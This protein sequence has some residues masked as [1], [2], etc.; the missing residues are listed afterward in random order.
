MALLLNGHPNSYSSA[1]MHPCCDFSHLIDAF[2]KEPR[3][4]TQLLW[5]AVGLLSSLFVIQLLTGLLSHSLSLL[6]DAGH[7][8]SDVIALG[9]SLAATRL[10]QQPAAGQA[11]FGHRRVEVLA[12]LV[13]G[14]ALLAIATIVAKEA[15]ER[16]QSSEP[17]LG[18]PMLIVAG[19]G[20]AVNSINI[21]LLYKASRNDLNIRG[22]FLHVVAD[23]ASSLGILFAALLIYL[24]NWTWIDAGVSLLIAISISLS[25]IPLV[26]D[27]LEVL[28][29]YAPRSVDPAKVEAALKSF[30]A[31]CE[32]E[33]LRI[34]TIGSGQ[35]AL[36]AHLIVDVT[37]GGERD[38]LIKQL[39]N[40][41]EREFDIGESTLQLTHHHSTELIELHPLLR[42]SLSAKLN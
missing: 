5:A 18:L 21:T 39:Q 40:H 42:S 25:S 4:K 12:A 14:L 35:V 23:T 2:S 36:C 11:T 31:V 9:I 30:V 16:F 6:A 3:Q 34:W 32:V 26:R 33:K 27:S 29:E 22:A 24:F 17:V 8:L 38:R 41:L 20:L 15:V 7:L 19:V 28:M 10:A 1:V 37:G 13:N